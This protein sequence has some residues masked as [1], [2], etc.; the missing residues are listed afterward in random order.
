MNNE[1]DTIHSAYVKAGEFIEKRE[2][3]FLSIL[4]FLGG[5]LRFYILPSTA[6]DGDPAR[7]LLVSQHILLYHEI[8]NI[9][10][11]ASGTNPIFYYPPVYYYLLAL[12]QIP[13][14]NTWYILSI[15]VLLNVVSIGI[16]Y[17]IA[18]RLSTVAS[19]L[20]ATLLYAFSSFYLDRQT[21][22]TSM[23]FTLP[24]LLTGTLF[25]LIGIQKHR[26]A[27][28]YIGLFFLVIS[29]SIN[30][31]ALILIPVYLLWT[32]IAF[33]KN[34]GNPIKFADFVFILFTLIYFSFARHV[35]LNYGL[36][37]FIAP[38]LP[39]NNI[40]VQN[41]PAHVLEQ[42]LLLLS[43]IFPLFTQGFAVLIIIA[44]IWALFHKRRNIQSILY[45]ASFLIMTLLLCAVKNMP[46]E[47]YYYYL[48]APFVFILIGKC[49]Q[50]IKVN[51][52]AVVFSLLIVLCAG[53]S[54]M[55]GINSL[56]YRAHTYQAAEQTVDSIL[57]QI[58]S[59]EGD[60]FGKNPRLVRLT[61]LNQGN[62]GWEGLAYSFFLEKKTG[63]IFRIYDHFNNL[64]WINEPLYHV[65]ICGVGKITTLSWCR[66][67][68]SSTNRNYTFIKMLSTNVP[69]PM[70]LYKRSDY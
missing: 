2:Y 56:F 39:G 60:R 54:S 63:K 16:F 44:I 61:L 40:T 47:S 36:N 23:H 43:T 14:T 8:P 30:Y 55:G 26:S 66:G 48:V 65:V 25:H 57:A 45:P 69:F 59:I 19:A 67:N 35:I 42:Y 70:L 53:W 50:L 28:V 64:E 58:A 49:I 24:L 11:V 7:D 37:E 38:F 33:R 21:S 10:H 13:S 9:G 17:H 18:K 27:Y 68:F 15:F 1:M 62:M 34:L 41:F 4:I 5:A 12:L 46:V 6:W 22:L 20:F 52:V 32:C 31:A 29:S 3:V 51:V